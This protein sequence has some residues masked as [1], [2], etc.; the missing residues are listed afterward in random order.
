MTNTSQA[1]DVAIVGSGIAGLVLS[2]LL[3]RRGIEHIVMNRRRRGQEPL[4]LGETLP[5]SAIPLLQSLHLNNL[6]HQHILR[7]TRGY[8]ISWGHEDLT[9]SNFY[10][11]NPKPMV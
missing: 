9:H 1:I 11:Q 10:F 5:P 2:I 7:K 4:A 6:F 3:Q 8:H